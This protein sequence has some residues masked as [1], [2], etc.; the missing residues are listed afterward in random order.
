MISISKVSEAS[1]VRAMDASGIGLN[2]EELDML[3]NRYR[4]PGGGGAIDYQRFCDQSNKVWQRPP[5]Q[6]KEERSISPFM[7]DW[8]LAL[9]SAHTRDK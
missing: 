9:T 5:H 8:C 4:V 6:R 3:V 7:L 2:R 1:F